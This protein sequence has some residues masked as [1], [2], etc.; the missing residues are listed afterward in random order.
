[1]NPYKWCMVVSDMKVWNTVNGWPAAMT[2]S[3]G[4]GRLLITTL[5]A[6]LDENPNVRKENDKPKDP[7]L[8]SDF[9]PSTPMDDLAEALESLQAHLKKNNLPDNAMLHLDLGIVYMETD[10]KAEALNQLQLS[11]RL[12]PQDVNVHWRLGRL[13]RSMGK[14]DQAKT[15]LGQA[16]AINQKQ[17]TTLIE[18][19][20]TTPAS[21]KPPVV[22]K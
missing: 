22:K 2:R 7:L 10:R 19:M 9:A 6:G 5:G 4:E 3:Y 18:V 1:M 16:R 8:I 11:E 14:T 12:N 17:D 20:S 13:Y 21:T 15:E